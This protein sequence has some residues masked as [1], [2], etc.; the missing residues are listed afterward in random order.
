MAAA[1]DL[2]RIGGDM[3]PS[4][5]TEPATLCVVTLADG[6]RF[7]RRRLHAACRAAAS[8]VVRDR[9]D[10]EDGEGGFGDAPGYTCWYHRTLPNGA[11]RAVVLRD[12]LARLY[13]AR[14]KRER[15][16]AT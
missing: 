2:H 3:M 15:K 14:A 1:P 4:F 8:A 10:C 6:R 9:C 11:C 13:M 5:S 12:R 16:E 7:R